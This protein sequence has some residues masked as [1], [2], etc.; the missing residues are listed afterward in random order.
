MMARPRLRAPKISALRA[1]ASG[2]TL[3]VMSAKLASRAVG[4]RHQIW[5]TCARGDHR[6]QAMTPHP[7][8]T[9]T[10]R[11]SDNVTDVTGGP[12][13][14]EHARHIHPAG[15]CARVSRARPTPL[16]GAGAGVRGLLH[17]GPR[18]HDRHRALPSIR[19]SLHVSDTKLQ[20]VL[21]A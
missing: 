18:R 2:E 14:D 7:A 16:A 11:R 6:D 21:I 17:D 3:E 12:K 19:N 5:A 20:W 15:L 4:R 10:P 8:R 9:D 1:P 13:T